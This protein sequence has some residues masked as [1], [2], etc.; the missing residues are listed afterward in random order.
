MTR[1]RGRV[2]LWPRCQ[3][4]PMVTNRAQRTRSHMDDTQR[5]TMADLS[6]ITHRNEGPGYH[7]PAPSQEARLSTEHDELPE[8]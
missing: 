6:E 7:E 1:A 5:S 8:P 3:R 2:R 4:S